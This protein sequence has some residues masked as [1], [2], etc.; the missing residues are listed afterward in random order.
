MGLNAIILPGW[1][2]NACV[3]WLR[4]IK[5]TSGPSMAKD[6]TSKYSDLRDDGIS[7]LYV[8]NGGKIS[9]SAVL[10]QD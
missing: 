3:K 10:H 8:S 6:E 7:E 4:T 2:G 9:A 1:E 5:V